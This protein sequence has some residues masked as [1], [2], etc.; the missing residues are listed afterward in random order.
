MR[1]AALVAM[2]KMGRAIGW[3]NFES[4]T[5]DASGK[6]SDAEQLLLRVAEFVESQS[7]FLRSSAFEASTI[8]AGAVGARSV[9]ALDFRTF[10]MRVLQGLCGSLTSNDVELIEDGS[11]GAAVD[12]LE[13]A[14]GTFIKA[15]NSW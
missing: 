5:T 6:E 8:I 11:G 1:G 12:P 4:S 13:L 3:V 15:W 7:D 10:I 14:R 9:H 2:A